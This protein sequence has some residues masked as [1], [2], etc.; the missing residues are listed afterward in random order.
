MDYLFRPSTSI[1]VT[2]IGYPFFLKKV[3]SD[4]FQGVIAI[5]MPIVVNLEFIRQRHKVVGL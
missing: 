2:A 5:A 4:P 3:S 1:V